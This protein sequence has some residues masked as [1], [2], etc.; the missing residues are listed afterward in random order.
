MKDIKY[1]QVKGQELTDK[2]ISLLNEGGSRRKIVF[3][4]PTGSGKTVMA[5]QTLA[6]I[7][8]ETV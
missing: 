8:D 3:E 7:V 5:C 4:A 2:V 6:N 1:Q